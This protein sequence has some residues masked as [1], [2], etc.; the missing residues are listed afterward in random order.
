M[1]DGEERYLS[2]FYNSTQVNGNVVTVCYSRNYNTNGDIRG[3]CK[4]T[5]VS[6][7][8][9]NSYINL[10]TARVYT[11]SK[12]PFSVASFSKEVTVAANGWSSAQNIPFTVPS[13]YV[14]LPGVCYSNN[15]YVILYNG[16]WIKGDTSAA[17]SLHNIS[18]SQVTVTV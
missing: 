2:A 14:A 8:D 7:K 12:Y 11:N 18:S 16:Y 9:N 1:K 4:I 6:Q 5:L 3:E 10:E 17:F 13:G 15:G